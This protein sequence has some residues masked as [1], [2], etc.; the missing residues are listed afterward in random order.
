[1]K[2]SELKK[3]SIYLGEN[4]DTVY[5]DGMETEAKAKAEVEKVMHSS[6]LYHVDEEE[7]AD[8]IMLSVKDDVGE[9]FNIFIQFDDLESEDMADFYDNLM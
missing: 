2:K 3:L 7:T 5:L 8:G 4:L 6:A 1:M 9:Y